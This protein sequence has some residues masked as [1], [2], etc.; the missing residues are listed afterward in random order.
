[1]KKH[2]IFFLLLA[3][4]QNGF[5]NSPDSE[6]PNTPTT[7]ETDLGAEYWEATYMHRDATATVV[8]SPIA[9]IYIIKAVIKKVLQAMDLVF[10]RLQ[11]VQLKIQA[12]VEAVKNVMAKARLEEIGA[13]VKEKKEIFD[14]YYEELWTVKNKLDQIKAVK[15]AIV[16]QG[17]LADNFVKIFDKFSGDSNF[18]DRELQII[19][20]V[21]EGMLEQSIAVISDLSLLIKDFEFKMQ[22]GNRL[23]LIQEKLGV[24]NGVTADFNGF[25]KQVVTMSLSRVKEASQ[26]N[27]M[28]AYYGIE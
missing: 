18:N 24:I 17:E 22:D 21:Y 15:D 19:Y 8:A 23:A 9:I 12:G 6:I 28:K 25:T 27:E 5:T 13:L 26:I 1:M 11:Q 2:L 7:S 16:A 20:G 10:Q 14:K 4:A 3:A